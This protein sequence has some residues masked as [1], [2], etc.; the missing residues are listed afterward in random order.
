MHHSYSLKVMVLSTFQ[1]FG[2][3]T[4]LKQSFVIHHI[5]NLHDNLTHNAVL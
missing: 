1:N 5:H 4:S 2:V 3:N